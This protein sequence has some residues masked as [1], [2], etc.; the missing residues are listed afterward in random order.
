MHQVRSKT[1]KPRI[2]RIALDADLEL[3]TT[4]SCLHKY[5]QGKYCKYLWYSG[6]A[7]LDNAVGDLSEQPGD[8]LSQHSTLSE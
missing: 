2:G 7:R 6:L 8:L 1:W 3:P 5:L 4:Y